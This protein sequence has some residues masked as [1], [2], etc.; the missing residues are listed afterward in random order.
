MTFPV[1]N[2]CRDATCRKCGT[3]YEA[4]EAQSRKLDFI[5]KPCR[6]KRD[7]AYRE[8]RKAVGLRVSGRAMPREYHQGYQEIYRLRPEVKERK[9]LEARQRRTC[10]IEQNK[11][12]VR[13]QTRSAILAGTLVRQPCEVCGAEKVDAHHDD[14]SKPLDVRWLCRT[15]HNEFHAKARGAA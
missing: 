15:H 11:A 13:R 9:R 3:I 6:A 7:R 12:R 14:Y 2:I 8:Q 4:S 10:P 5:C 1:M